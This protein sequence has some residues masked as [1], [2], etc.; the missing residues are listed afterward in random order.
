MN[1]KSK[2]RAKLLRKHVKQGLGTQAA[3]LAQNGSRI[4]DGNREN[5]AFRYCGI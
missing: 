4:N 3:L 5:A 2:R 1:I